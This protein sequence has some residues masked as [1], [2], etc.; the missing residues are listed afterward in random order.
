M[1]ESQ[2]VEELSKT[3]IM[4]VKLDETFH[5]FHCDLLFCWAINTAALPWP[6]YLL[7]VKIQKPRGA[8]R[9]IS[10]VSHL[11]LAHGHGQGT[12][13]VIKR[14]FRPLIALQRHMAPRQ[15]SCTDVCQQ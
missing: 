9:V 7:Y 10:M 15:T 13:S 8:D 1:D 2:K 3:A 14:S 12:L 11:E 5:Y 6:A 4:A